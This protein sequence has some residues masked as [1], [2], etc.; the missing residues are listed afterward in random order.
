[1]RFFDFCSGIGGGRI[2]LEAAGH[3][4]VGYCEKDRTADVIFSYL[5]GDCRGFGDIMLVDPSRL[6]DFDIMLAGFPYKNFSAS[7]KRDGFNDN[8][9]HVITALTGILSVKRPSYFIFENDRGFLSYN[10]G[11]AFRTVCGALEN[12]GY[13]VFTNILNS[14][15]YGIPHSRERVYLVGA[16]KGS[17]ENG[18]MWPEK[19]ECRPVSEFLCDETAPVLPVS[20]PTFYAG[21]SND[22]NRGRIFIDELLA[23]DYTVIDRRWNDYRVHTDK[24]PALSSSR[25]GIV[26]TL[27]GELRKIT[28]YEALL[29]QGFPEKT[30]RKA[31][32]AGILRRDRKSV[33]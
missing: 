15:D 30:A 4:C 12:A 31:R 11:R 21:L 6:P 24:V 8:K 33:V 14:S 26:Y 17:W 5:T 29:L 16:P 9:A 22:F 20:D 32:D 19:T 10:G 25:T 23:T 28:A 3:T 27:N 1:M 2:A 7:G 18:F 13:D